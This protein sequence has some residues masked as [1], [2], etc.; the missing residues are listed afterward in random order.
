M[1]VIKNTVEKIP[2]GEGID[3]VYYIFNFYSY[4]QSN[5]SYG[6]TLITFIVFVLI[7]C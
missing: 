2:S 7:L 4:V 3:N 5:D 1:T 6:I